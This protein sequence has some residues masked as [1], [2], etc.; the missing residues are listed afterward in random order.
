ML[1]EY[2]FDVGG[3]SASTHGSQVVVVAPR[4]TPDMWTCQLGP[5]HVISVGFCSKVN[6][7]VGGASLATDA[8][9]QVVSL[10]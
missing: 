1:A 4:E 8:P 10:I 9:N 2:A 3:D 5:L 6:R 7:V